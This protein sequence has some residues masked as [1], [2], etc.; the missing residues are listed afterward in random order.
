[1]LRAM[2]TRNPDLNCRWA[3]L[4][5]ALHEF[6]ELSVSS[7]SSEKL[8]SREPCPVLS[9]LRRTCRVVVG[10]ATA[11]IEAR[12]SSPS[13]SAVPPSLWTCE[14]ALRL[15]FGTYIRV[16]VRH[17]KLPASVTYISLP[18]SASVCLS[19]SRASVCL[20]LSR[21]NV[22]L[23]SRS[24]SCLISVSESAINFDLLRM[25]IAKSWHASSLPQ[26]ENI[27]V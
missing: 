19:L 25:Q 21:L 22:C 12:F 7:P 15:R 18:L 1:M 16:A 10:P 6:S 2:G 27:S 23:A 20:S 24:A 8:G 9:V 26:G 17:T 4:E 5:W 14:T 13:S 11:S 3:A